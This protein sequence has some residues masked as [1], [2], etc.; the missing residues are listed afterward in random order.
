MQRASHC[1]YLQKPEKENEIIE[2]K[3]IDK[4]T[5]GSTSLTI[6]IMK[7]K[8]H[9]NKPARDIFYWLRISMHSTIEHCPM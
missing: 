7:T 6:W 9:N 5:R 1:I 8:A 4:S 3:T 2:D